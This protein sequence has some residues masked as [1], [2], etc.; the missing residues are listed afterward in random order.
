MASLPLTA[1]TRSSV[2]STAL[3]RLVGG[4]AATP[5]IVIYFVAPLY[6]LFVM[7]LILVRPFTPASYLFLIPI[8]VSV[9]A[10]TRWLSIG[11]TL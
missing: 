8:I 3:E 10:P 2:K 5:F 7:L 9:R 6:C 4:I 11:F 1:P